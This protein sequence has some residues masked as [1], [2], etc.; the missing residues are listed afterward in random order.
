MQLRAAVRDRLDV[1]VV[2]AI[3]AHLFSIILAQTKVFDLL[4]VG[5]RLRW[6]TLAA[7]VAV[8]VGIGRARRHRPTCEDRRA[9][10][11]DR[12]AGRVCT[13]VAAWTVSPSEA[14][15]TIP[16]N[17]GT[18][19][20]LRSAAVLGS[21]AAFAASGRVAAV[22]N[23]VMSGATAVAVAGLLVLVVDHDAAIEP[24]TSQYGERFNALGGNPNAAATLEALALPLALAAAIAAA[25]AEAIGWWAI[26]ALLFASIAG[27]AA[28]GSRRPPSAARD[29]GR[30]CA[31]CRSPR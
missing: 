13:V 30:R 8:A 28:A 9:A 15:F 19:G 27:S 26:V 3:A 14:V 16:D 7:L 23:G 24:A 4:S 25:G 22:A 6:V 10:R 20:R 18:S 12:R 17:V 5:L 29:G 2:T 21:A 11:A 31:A 1:V